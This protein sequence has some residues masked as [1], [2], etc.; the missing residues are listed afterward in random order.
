[1]SRRDVV[2]AILATTRLAK[3]ISEEAGPWRLAERLR[4]WVAARYGLDSWQF[5]GVSCPLC[6]SFWL[7]WGVAL[8]PRPALRALGVAA[9]AV[10]LIRIGSTRS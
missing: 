5:E 8:L 9:G 4:S 10:E 2:L 1:M 7:A 3:L 6:V